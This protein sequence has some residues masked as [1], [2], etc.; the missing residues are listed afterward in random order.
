MP[1]CQKI[2]LSGGWSLDWLVNDSDGKP[3]AF[4][5]TTKRR[6]AEE[7]IRKTRP[8]LLIGSPKCT[9]FLNIMNLAQ[10]VDRLRFMFIPFELR[11]SLGGYILFEHPQNATSWRLDFV[12]AMKWRPG[13]KCV[14][15]HVCRF[16]MIGKDQLGQGLVMKPIRFMT[17]CQGIVPAL[18]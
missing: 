11:L 12:E 15:A 17:D 18:G 8:R 6:D 2:I 9:Y 5:D 3:W 4:D 14:I 1:F 16:G 7:L 10:A 13:M